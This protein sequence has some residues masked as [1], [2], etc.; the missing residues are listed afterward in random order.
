MARSLVGSLAS[1]HPVLPDIPTRMVRADV[2]K[3]DID[4]MQA[5]GGAIARAVALA[6]LS[7]KEAA[8]HV[9]VDEAE[10]G[11]WLSGARRPH[12]DRLFAV[13]ALRQPLGICLADLTQA[14]VIDVVMRTRR[15]A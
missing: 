15:R 14:F 12:F 2:Q 3:P 11:K 7:H 5:I 4:W 8:G 9:G 10:F 6:G 1:G 13:K